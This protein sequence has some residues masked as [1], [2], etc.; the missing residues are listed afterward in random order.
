MPCRI[1]VNASL[2]GTAPTRHTL[3][4][5]PTILSLIFARNA[6]IINTLGNNPGSIN[7]KIIR[8]RGP[9]SGKGKTSGRGHGGQKA[10]GKVPFGFQG[11]QTPEWKV[12]GIKGFVN[13]NSENMAE[14]NLDRLQTWIDQGRINPNRPITVVELMRSGCISSIK[15]GVKILARGREVLKTPV[16]LIVSRASTQA[17][18]AIEAV[19]GTITTRFYTI[20]AMKNI[21]QGLTH[22]VHSRLFRPTPISNLVS[23]PKESQYALPDPTGRKDLEYYRNAAHRGYLSYMVPPGETP[24]LFFK[25]PGLHG[26][27]SRKDK[28]STEDNR[29]W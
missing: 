28:A 13:R 16:H 20:P 7:K 6:S 3:R 22:P 19:G 14:V 9:G 17:I 10:R 15:D 4:P 11:G 12:A 23:A 25:T 21:L 8:G 2:L 5:Q 1:P 18:E 24:S 27:K 26:V 29:I